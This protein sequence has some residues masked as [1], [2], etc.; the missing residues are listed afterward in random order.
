MFVHTTPDVR[1]QGIE[2]RSAANSR[3]ADSKSIGAFYTLHK[4]EVWC[5]ISGGV[6]L[7]HTLFL[8]SKEFVH[9]SYR[10]VTLAYPTIGVII[11][12]KD[13]HGL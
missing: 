5:M 6:W 11:S 13:R 12:K 7:S 8:S 9:Q 4:F 1:V 3:R 2:P 10:Y